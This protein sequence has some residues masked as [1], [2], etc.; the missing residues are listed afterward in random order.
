VLEAL[1]DKFEAEGVDD[2][3]NI[4]VLQVQPIAKLGTPVELVQRFG[5]KEPYLQ[6]VRGLEDALYDA[7]REPQSA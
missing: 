5:G 3:E 6:A 7:E 4:R 1:L 2:L